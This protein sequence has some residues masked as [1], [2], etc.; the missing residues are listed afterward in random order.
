MSDH[1]TVITFFRP[2]EVER[3]TWTLSAELYNRCRLLLSRSRT[4]CVFV[5]IRSMQFQGVIDKE[6]IIFVD[7]QGGYLVQDGTGGR[8]ILVA[9]QPAHPHQRESLSGPVPCDV[10]YYGH[11]LYDLQR[12]L[13][14]EFSKALLQ[15][16]Q[17]H[18]NQEVQTQGAK[19]VALRV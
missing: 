15:L 10:V 18:R 2:C 14:G 1:H 17:K 16:H 9:W 3:R 5:P 11:D 7:S 6:E 13:V 4:G 19:V 12:Q 8:P